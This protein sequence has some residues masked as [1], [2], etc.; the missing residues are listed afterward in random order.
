MINLIEISLL[1][2]SIKNTKGTN[3]KKSLL[4]LALNSEYSNDLKIVLNHLF[5]PM[6][7]T[8]IS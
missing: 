7:S 3:A 8:G 5:N 1:F 6:I 4:E 2:E